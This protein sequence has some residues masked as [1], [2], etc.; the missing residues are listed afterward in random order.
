MM[1]YFY[2]VKLVNFVM[3]AVAHVNQIYLIVLDVMMDIGLTLI[4]VNLVN[5]VVKNAWVFNNVKFVKM[6]IFFYQ[7]LVFWY[8]Q[9]DILKQYKIR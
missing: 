2:R 7:K 8:V 1:V 4:F 3:I 5:K 9:L 6:D